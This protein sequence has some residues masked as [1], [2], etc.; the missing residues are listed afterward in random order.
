[1]NFI[2]ASRELIAN[3][4]LE[5]LYI[6]L[7]PTYQ[8]YYYIPNF[9]KTLVNHTSIRELYLE[10]NFLYSKPLD[11]LCEGLQIQTSLKKLCL[12]GNGFGDEGALILS[13]LI[14]SINFTR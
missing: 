7:A 6:E 4:N 2:N 13:D 3:P 9:V 10:N 12:G 5:I 11:C 8:D 14:N 1:M